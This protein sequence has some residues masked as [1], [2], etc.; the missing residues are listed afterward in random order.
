MSELDVD[1]DLG[2]APP[3]EPKKKSGRKKQAVPAAQ[4]EDLVVTNGKKE[5]PL[6]RGEERVQ[7]II[8]EVPGMSNYEVVGV[9]G[10]LYQI[11]RGVPVWVPMGVVYALQDAVMTQTEIRRHPVT[12]EREEIVRHHSAIPWRRV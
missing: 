7:I 2:I 5:V 1:L 10:T 8:D 3:S 11:K 6:P 12:G 4:V 9:N